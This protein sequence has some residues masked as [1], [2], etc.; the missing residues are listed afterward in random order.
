MKPPNKWIVAFT[1]ILPTLLEVLDISVVNV[2]L[3]HIRGSLSAGVDEATWSIT[4]YLVANAI[5][6]PLAGW[7]SGII[8]RKRYLMASI[9]LFTISSF[10]C[11][12]AH[13]LGALV[14]FRILQGIAGGGLQPLSQAIL[15]EA[16]PPAQYGIAMAVFGVGV[17]VGPIAGPVLGGWITDNWSWPWIFYINI[18]LGI[19]SLFMMNLFIED[20]PY[21]KKPSGL[22]EKIDFLG[23]GLIVVGI[24]CLQVV[25]DH[26]QREDWFSSRLITTLTILSAAALILFIIVELR[27]REPVLNLRVFRDASFSAGTIIQA[28]AFSMYMGTLIMLPLFLQQLMGYNALLAGMALMPGGVGMLLS[29]AVVGKLMEKVNPKLILGAGICLAAY[30]M[31]MLVGINLYIDYETIAWTR[32]VMGIGLGMVVVP[33]LSLSFSSIKKEVMGNATSVYTTLRTLSLSLGTAFVVTL[34]SRRTQFHQSRLAEDLNPFDPRFQLALQKIGPLVKAKTGAASDI[35][36]NGVIYQQLMKEA[37][38][39]SFMDT[40]FV[41]ALI[42]ACVLPLIF[43][44]KK[45]RDGE[46]VIV[47]H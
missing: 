30:S 15:L 21:L 43:F 18:P 34:F 10:L 35:M 4:A 31:H 13:S 25:L 19:L 42:V 1:V 2:S 32:I 28:S 39:A 22:K 5:I 36:I 3:D 8:G 23:I 38:L 26:G 37:A 33:L 29:M 44:L 16:F 6:I 40:F 17:M 11:G 14:V 45:P 24:G 9:I 41:S 47:M 27:I 20:P 7:L 46:T 12:S